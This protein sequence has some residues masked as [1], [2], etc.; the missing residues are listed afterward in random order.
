MKKSQSI[1][2]TGTLFEI[3]WSTL[4]VSSNNSKK[5]KR[6]RSTKGTRLS[7]IVFFMFV[8]NQ[9]S[10]S[11]GKGYQSIVVVMVTNLYY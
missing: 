6:Y 9:D 3:V 4:F 10:A 2:S 8:K 11:I 7:C 1:F 5:S